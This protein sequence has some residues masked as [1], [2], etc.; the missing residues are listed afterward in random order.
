MRIEGLVFRLLSEE[1]EKTPELIPHIKLIIGM[2]SSHQKWAWESGFV[3]NISEINS[4]G[5]K[6]E[7]IAAL[8]AV[9]AV[10]DLLDEDSNRCDTITLIKY[11]HGTM[12]NLAHWIRHALTVEVDGVKQHKVKV[13]FRKLFPMG[14][15]Y[16]KIYRALRNHYRLVKLYNQQLKVLDAKIEYLTF[17]PPD[18]IPEYIDETANKLSK[19]WINI[20]EFKN[21]IVEQILSTFMQEALN[22]DGNHPS[23]RRRLNEI[24]VETI[25]LSKEF[26]FMRPKTILYPEEKIVF[27]CKNFHECL[28][29]VKSKVEEAYLNGQ[30]GAV[31]HLSYVAWKKWK[32]EAALDDVYWI[33]VF[34][35]IYEKYGNEYSEVTSEYRNNQ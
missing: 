20:P 3:S 17:L 18:G 31:R 26:K 24:G 33:Y 34:W 28:S 32:E 30:I 23:M 35:G 12:E 25:D 15:G 29:Y 9:I 2:A 27:G 1:I 19:I 21:H 16:E 7:R 6:E 22:F 8:N 11:R 14:V 5:L 4:L 10:C 13:I